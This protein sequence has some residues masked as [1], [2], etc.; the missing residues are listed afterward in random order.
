MIHN[1][2]EVLDGNF[3]AHQV[4]TDPDEGKSSLISTRKDKIKVYSSGKVNNY[5]KVLEKMEFYLPE[6]YEI[7]ET[8]DKALISNS[9]RKDA[10]SWYIDMDHV[11]TLKSVLP[12][13]SAYAITDKDL[14]SNI[15]ISKP[16]HPHIGSGQH[17]EVGTKTKLMKRK[18]VFFR[19]EKLQWVLQPLLTNVLLW[20]G[21]HKFDIRTYA[22]IYNVGDIFKAA[23]YKVG[24]CRRCVNVHDPIKDPMSA[25][26]NISVQHKIHG[27]DSEFHMPMIYDDI[28]VGCNMLTDILSK[29]TLKRDPRKKT[30]FLIIGMDI[31]FLA[32]GTPKLI[33]V[34]TDPYI[35]IQS[36]VTNNEKMA[37]EGFILGAFGYI[38][39]SLL[40]GTGIRKMKDWD[41]CN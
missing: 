16:S 9:N 29:T 14:D 36:C 24:I 32:D 38:L 8:E 26:S 10:M 1:L 3:H 41:F 4:Y 30:Q 19:K 35:E 40:K 11:F 5:G 33:E 34:N 21:H 7:V 25:I 6:I 20:S 15:W 23:C 22:V 13:V 31:L 39:P 17:I 12:I 28:N 37:S 2:S 18:P 27:Y